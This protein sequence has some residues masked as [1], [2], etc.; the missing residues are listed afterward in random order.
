MCE[1]IVTHTILKL[2]VFIKRNKR[3]LSTLFLHCRL[4]HTLCWCCLLYQRLELSI[5]SLLFSGLH[6]FRTWVPRHLISIIWC[7]EKIWDILAKNLD[8]LC[9][10]I[11]TTSSRG[12]HLL[13]QRFTHQLR[14]TLII[15]V[16]NSSSGNCLTFLI[17][18][19]LGKIIL[20]NKEVAMRL[21]LLCALGTI[22]LRLQHYPLLLL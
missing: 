19:T 6:C 1:N 14:S 15:Y 3:G 18:R 8:F 16:C 13:L 4:L 7:G 20:I 12:I 10:A 5:D 17:V 9:Y 22:Q 2:I 21:D 11:I